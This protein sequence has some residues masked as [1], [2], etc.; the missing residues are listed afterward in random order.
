MLAGVSALEA[1]LPSFAAARTRGGVTKG[2]IAILG[3]AQ[4]AEA[5]AVTTYTN[6]IDTAPFFTRLESD[7]QGYLKAARRRRCPITCWR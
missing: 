1:L 2:D 4:I 6:I 5:L 7:D 3:A